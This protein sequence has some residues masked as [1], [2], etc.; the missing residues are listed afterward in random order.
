[1][2]VFVAG[3][4]VCCLTVPASWAGNHKNNN[5]PGAKP[6]GLVA[7]C[8]PG[9]AKKNPPCVPPG[10][11]KRRYP[12]GYLPLFRIGDAINRDYRILQ[13]PRRYGL[14]DGLL[15]YIVGREV[16]RISP[17]TGQVLAFIGLTDWLLN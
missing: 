6:P 10:Q 5:R 3:L 4:I 11:A 7:N 14:E 13:N 16:F 8:P 15:Y 9:L 2:R 12:D 17:E 1:M